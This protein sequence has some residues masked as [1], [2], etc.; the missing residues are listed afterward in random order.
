MGFD[1]QISVLE[2]TSMPTAPKCSRRKRE[3][4]SEKESLCVPERK[5]LA[6]YIKHFC[7]FQVTENI[8]Q[9]LFRYD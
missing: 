7:P 8:L 9:H 2:A 1:L 4:E 3:R 5:A 6:K